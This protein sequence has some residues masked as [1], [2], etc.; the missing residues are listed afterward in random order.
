[1]RK[2]F[3]LLFLL[4]FVGIA[5]AQS[6]NRI[7][8]QLTVTNATTNGFAFILNADQRTVTNTPPSSTWFTTNH[9]IAGSASNL[10]NNI[11][12][13]PFTRARVYGYTNG[14]NTIYIRGDLGVAMAASA[15]SNWLHISYSTQ[16]FSSG[17]VDVRVPIASE[18]AN[19]ATN[20]ASLLVS[21]IGV[22]STNTFAT[23]ATAL[24]NHIS[25]GPSVQVLVNDVFTNGHV[26]GGAVSNLYLTN[27]SRAN[28]NLL[29]A[30]NYNLLGGTASNA[31][32]TNVAW[33]NGTIG[34]TTN[35][36]FYNAFITNSPAVQTTNLTAFGGYLSNIYGHSII[37]T[38]LSAP[39]ATNYT[40]QIGE[41][42][43]AS[44]LYAT[45]LGYAAGALA[46]QSVAIGGAI[47]GTNG[48]TSIAI[49]NSAD[50]TNVQA[51]AIGNQA[52]AYGRRA[53]SM[54]REATATA[55][56]T[57]AIGYQASATNFNQITLG[58]AS[59]YLNVPGRIE[60]ATYTNSTFKGTNVWSGSVIYTPSVNTGLA[61]G[62]NSG[63]V[64]GTN[65]WLQLSGPSAAYTNVGFAA[66]PSGAY[67]KLSFDNPVSAVAILDNSGLEATAANRI[68]TG[69]GGVLVLTNNPA[70]ADVIYDSSVSRWRVISHSH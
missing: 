34:G 24:A 70:W 2:L 41:L 61:N 10:Y 28:I 46:A 27:I 11:V 23:N 55:S 33:F 6:T 18:T 14:S 44:A 15:L 21:G 50:V 53:V 5:S 20:I 1:M 47:V 56:N 38:N 43:E 49:G 31:T 9:T 35:G 48:G 13:N 36:R 62:Y 26:T 16:V 8:V 32:L 51:I 60:D 59:H 29:M 19:Q 45:A 12:A 67:H 66:E 37:I 58:N 30:T 54:G 39:G 68:R 64:L 25:V 69:T 3:T 4:A 52:K 22:Y 40:V 42:A 57:V 63:I 65:V 17:L 7:T